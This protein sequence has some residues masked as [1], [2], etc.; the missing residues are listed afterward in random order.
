[1]PPDFSFE[2][3]RQK[4]FSFFRGKLL[5]RYAPFVKKSLNEIFFISSLLLSLPL[6]SWE[7][8]SLQLS[9]PLFSWEPLS[10]PL[11][12]LLFSSVLLSLLLPLGEA[13][14]IKI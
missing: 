10:L 5:H 7:L 8:L 6:F 13:S 11:S 14:F 2:A 4:A 12:L 1:M 3:Q 9:L